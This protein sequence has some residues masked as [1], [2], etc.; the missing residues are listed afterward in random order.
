[1]VTLDE[2][3][4]VQ[5]II[6]CKFGGR[7]E[8]PTIKHPMPLSGFIK[9]GESGGTITA[10]RKM[11]HYKKG[12]SQEFAW[13]R[14]KKNKGT[15]TQ[16]AYLASGNLDEQVKAF[17]N[18]LELDSKFIDWIRKVLKRRNREEFDFDHKQRELLTKKLDSIATR[19]E[20][21]FD[22]KI[23][24]LYE[25]DEYKKKKAELLKEEM[26]I[27]EQLNTDRISY[28]EQVIEDTLNFSKSILE[29][30]NTGDDYTKRLVLQ[31]LGTDLIL[32]DKKLYIKAKS[33]F[34]FL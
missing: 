8:T 2:F 31:I 34:I 33:M 29:Q 28:R 11:K 6:K 14:C 22:M 5:N 19:K 32:K 18:N 9:C 23:D 21:V 3:N 4:K 12:T 13:Y 20:R 1:M 24:G 15:C 7:Y 16:K 27:K 17:I 26:E 10:D 25:E 30:F